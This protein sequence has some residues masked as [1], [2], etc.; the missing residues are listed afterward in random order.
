MLSRIHIHRNERKIDSIKILDSESNKSISALE[1]LNA[2]YST[3]LSD[4]EQKHNIEIQRLKEYELKTDKPVT[5]VQWL[6]IENKRLQ[7]EIDREN[8]SKKS[9]FSDEDL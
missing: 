4:L 1:M 7:T 8:T 3:A 6:T 9:N 5:A 2:E